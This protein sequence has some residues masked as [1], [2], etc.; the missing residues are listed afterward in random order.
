MMSMKNRLPNF[1]RRMSDGEW[2][3]PSQQYITKAY[4]QAKSKFNKANKIRARAAKAMDKA[5]VTM[6]KAHDV[7]I[8]ELK[9]VYKNSRKRR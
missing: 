6:D 2:L 8:A 5:S 4:L 3:N 9:R 7:M 1:I